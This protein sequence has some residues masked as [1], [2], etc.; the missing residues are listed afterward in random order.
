MIIQMGYPPQPPYGGQPGYGQ[1]VPPQPGQGY[2]YPPQA[3]APQQ[4][5]GQQ[6]PGY[7][8]AP[9]QGGYPPQASPFAG[10]QAPGA[11]GATEY[12]FAD[13]YG[14]ADMS[15]GTL[16]EAGK[17]GAFVESADWGRSRD[18]TKGQWTVV[19][20]T[21]TG[22][23]LM[24]LQGGGAKLT[25][26]LSIS[27]KKNDGTDNPA[28][29]GILFK[30]LHALGVPL[31]PPLDGPE[32][33]PFWAQGISEQQVAAMITGKPAVLG[34]IQDEYEGVTRNKVRQ[35]LPP[36]PGIPASVPQAPQQPQQPYG[37]GGWLPPQGPVPGAP[38]AVAVPAQPYAPAP[39]PQ[40]GPPPGYSQPVAP[41]PWQPQQQSW[42]QGPPPQSPQQAGGGYDPNMP[43][44]TQPAQPGQPGMGQFSPDGQAVQPGTVPGQPYPSQNGA[45]QQPA[46]QQ[47]GAPEMPP[48]AQ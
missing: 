40:N 17:Y 7:G 32:V 8:Y 38:G 13:V 45:P 10:P 44:Y 11:P 31:G 41:Q 33:T 39:V 3:P 23:N 14:K 29:L 28:G 37:Q 35:I 34:V 22:P 36:Q 30:Q 12:N 18:G 26:T 5:Y 6:P 47:G 1:P 4:G 2:G 42:A 20:R 16:L 9:Q 43:P 46:P 24:P 25:T 15:A 27:P 48:W 19:F 21:T